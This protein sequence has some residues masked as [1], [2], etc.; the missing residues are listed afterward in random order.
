MLEYISPCSSNVTNFVKEKMRLNFHCLTNCGLVRSLNEDSYFADNRLNCFLVADGMGGQA[1]GELASSIM[2]ETVEELCS[3]SAG[4]SSTDLQGMIARCFMTANVRILAHVK[5]VQ[6]HAGMGCTADL[7]AFGDTAFVLGH[8]GDS[9]C[10]RL[11]ERNL[12][13]LSRDHT[14]VQ[15]QFDQGLIS[16]EQAKTH[17]MKNVLLR[18]VGVKKELEVDFIHGSVSPGDIFLLCSD[19]LTGMVDDQK[20]LEILSYDGP[21]SLKATMLID[22]AL[23]AG[24]RDNVTVILIEAE[25]VSDN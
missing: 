4:R 1:A 2:R 23:Y 25:N 5:E 22:E 6:S 21:L 8:V 13:Q 17:S 20:I 12:E 16:K 11:R 24:G 15:S 7:L 3:C 19:G 18:V 10:Y 14:L 9:R